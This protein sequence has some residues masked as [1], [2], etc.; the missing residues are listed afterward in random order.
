MLLLFWHYAVDGQFIVE[1]SFGEAFR[2]KLRCMCTEMKKLTPKFSLYI[3]DFMKEEL[4]P[5]VQHCIFGNESYTGRCID[6][7]SPVAWLGD[8]MNDQQYDVGLHLLE[9]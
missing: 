6:G 9:G 2:E 4:A 1:E 7:V 8:A 3:H 5:G